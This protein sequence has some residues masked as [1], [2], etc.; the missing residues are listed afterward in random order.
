MAKSNLKIGSPE[1]VT[2]GSGTGGNVSNDSS[3]ISTNKASGSSFSV[4]ALSLGRLISVDDTVWKIINIYN[5]QNY[6]NMTDLLTLRSFSLSL[7]FS[8]SFND[9]LDG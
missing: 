2:T 5:T 7:K 1:G 4:S 9:K 8:A 3:S 6:V